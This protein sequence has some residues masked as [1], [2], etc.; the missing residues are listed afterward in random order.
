M[1]VQIVVATQEGKNDTYALLIHNITNLSE[2]DKEQI[3]F[4]AGFYTINNCGAQSSL[5]NLFHFTQVMRVI[6]CPTLQETATL[7][8]LG[9]MPFGLIRKILKKHVWVR[10]DMNM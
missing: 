6:H 1:Q 8:F 4:A 3:G 10:T 9:F 5:Y 7:A 2:E